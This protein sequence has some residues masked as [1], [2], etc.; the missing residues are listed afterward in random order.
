MYPLHQHSW[1]RTI[2]LAEQ[3]GGWAAGIARAER[4]DLVSRAS[5]IAQEFLLRA[6][7]TTSARLHAESQVH[8]EIQIT[9]Y[10]LRMAMHVPGSEPGLDCFEVSTPEIS[11]GV[12]S[13]WHGHEMWA[14]LRTTEAVPA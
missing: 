1:P 9:D 14:T 12:S 10:G 8:A 5:A 4:P 7:A 6:A 13:G 3:V 11:I 2:N